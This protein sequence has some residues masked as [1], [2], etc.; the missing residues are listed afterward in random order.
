MDVRQ[1]C[2]KQIFMLRWTQSLLR[3]QDCV[4]SNIFVSS[5]RKFAVKMAVVYT[6]TCK[7]PKFHVA[8]VRFSGFNLVFRTVKNVIANYNSYCHF[9]LEYPSVQLSPIY[10]FELNLPQVY[11]YGIPSFLICIYDSSLIVIVCKSFV[12]YHYHCNW[13]IFWVCLS[14]LLS[15]VHIR[16]YQHPWDVWH[17]HLNI[18]YDVIRS[19]VAWVGWGLGEQ[20]DLQILYLQKSKHCPT[21]LDYCETLVIDASWMFWS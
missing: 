20:W 10:G 4:N 19:R 21:P 8:K 5:W 13:V 6:C 1:V 12:W 2:C 9:N 11:K 16:S 18:A 14:F 7:S 15:I 17:H 3:A